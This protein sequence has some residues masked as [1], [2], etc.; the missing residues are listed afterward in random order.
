[1]TEWRLRLEGTG[2]RLPKKW[3]RGRNF[4]E[5]KERKREGKKKMRKSK[6]VRGRKRRINRKIEKMICAKEEL[7]RRCK[8]FSEGYEIKNKRKRDREWHNRWRFER[9]RDDTET[10]KYNKWKES[11]RKETR[12]VE[13]EKKK[14]NA[15]ICKEIERKRESA[16]NV[17]N[18]DN[19]LFIH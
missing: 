18:T 3:E 5:D 4:G 6:R 10:M 11:R 15:Q 16:G 13:D 14:R 2:E 17:E 12:N 1:M 9:E 8:R 19:M 7:I